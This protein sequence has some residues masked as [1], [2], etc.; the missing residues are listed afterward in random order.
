M[1]ATAQKH[2]VAH[3][4][5]RPLLVYD[6]DCGFCLL[7]VSRWREWLAGHID[8]AP[9]QAAAERF[10]EISRD[11]FEQAVQLILPDGRVAGGAAAVFE[12]MSICGET[13]WVARLYRRFPF[14]ATCA[15][16]AYSLV[17]RNRTTFSRIARFLHGRDLSHP[18]FNLSGEIFF[19]LLGVIYLFA[20]LS[21][22]SQV[23][24]LA[25]EHGIVP[26]VRLMDAVRENHAGFWRLPTLCHF[27][28][29]GDSSLRLLCAAGTAAS[30][31]MMLGV[32]PVFSAFA[33]WLIYLSICSVIEVFLNFQ[34]DALLLETGFLAIFLPPMTLSLRWGA[35][36]VRADRA[37]T[38]RSTQ[39]SRLARWLIVWL[40][41][42]MM[43]ATGVVKL[44]SGDAAWWNLTALTY[45]YWTQCLPPWTAWYFDKMPVWA[46]R[47]C[48]LIM[49]VIELAVPF[50]VFFP[51]RLRHFAAASFTALMIVILVS[52]NYGF[53]NL[54]TCVLCV[55]L[56]DDQWWRKL[57]PRS[58]NVPN[59]S[60]AAATRYFRRLAAPV[61]LLV[62]AMSWLPFTR[63]IVAAQA[64]CGV[65]EPWRPAFPTW[66]IGLHNS[67]SPFR[68]ING[69]GLFAVMTKYRDEII[70]EGTNDG[71]TWLPYEFKWK[72][73]D[74]KRRPPFSTPHMPRLDWQMWF[75]ALGDIRGDPWLVNL[76]VRLL[77]GEPT[78]I[79]LLG[80]NPFPEK[81]PRAI[82]A[83]AYGYHF[84]TFAERRETGAWWKRDGPPRDYC[85]PITLRDGKPGIFRPK[86]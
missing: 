17:A 4:P 62:F 20:F 63:A 35:H 65:A 36:S 71:V 85:P 69:Y 5:E 86:R 27:I 42:R 24:G 70:L 38:A 51:R 23:I 72:P 7:M 53:F 49:F 73:D 26:A 76:I 57:F 55:P 47:L 19:R 30:V 74:V 46:H 28:G 18:T 58:A 80:R 8:D 9:F 33:S 77:N 31:L 79:T 66:L 75:A 56:V 16:D 22:W 13:P 54:L 67:V 21:L 68:S 45:H 1:G 81:P 3:P 34:W 84:T 78:V 61:L 2:R 41:F 52:G 40:V 50:L 25:G 11:E 43:F 60:P 59:A 82:R 44:A 64:I 15:D 48:C 29:A 10:P 14:F 6:G 37:G 39:F 83:V 12:A 32:L